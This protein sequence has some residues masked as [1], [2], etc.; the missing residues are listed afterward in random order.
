MPIIRV[1]EGDVSVFDGDA[2]VNAANNHLKMGAGVAGALLEAGGS[3]IQEEC[4]EY[5]RTNGPLEVGQAALTGAG[6]L[7]ARFIIHA[8]AMGDL[9]ASEETIRSSV[10]S[11]LRLAIVHG[12]KSIAF[13]ILGTGVGKFPFEQ[14]AQAMTSEIIEASRDGEIPDQVVLYGYQP[15]QAATLRRLIT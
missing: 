8:A 14:A 10:R 6:R 2:I 1:A 7:Q 12:V 13:P 3:Q 11:A 9:P 4:D 15:H 5:V